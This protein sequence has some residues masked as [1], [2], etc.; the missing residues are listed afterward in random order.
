M[1]SWVTTQTNIDLTKEQNDKDITDN[2]F[3]FF[4]SLV[5]AQTEESVEFEES[6]GCLY[7]N[8]NYKYQYEKQTI[9][10]KIEFEYGDSDNSNIKNRLKQSVKF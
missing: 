2:C 9:E 6:D 7:E 10:N 3:F 8:I 4:C 1:E 5:A